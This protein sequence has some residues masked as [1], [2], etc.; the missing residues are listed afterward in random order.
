MKETYTVLVVDD[1]PDLRRITRKTLE[2]RGYRVLEAAD[3]A[4]AL[5]LLDRWK[6]DIDLAI[7]DVVMPGVGGREFLWQASE[8]FPALP[9]ILCSGLVDQPCTSLGLE[10]P[11]AAFIPKPFEPEALARLVEEVLD[12]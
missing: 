5:A 3:G 12:R 6:D 11:P 2:S 4:A 9:V 1:K 10:A 8:R 7:A